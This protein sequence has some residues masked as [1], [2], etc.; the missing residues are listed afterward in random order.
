M[1][2]TLNYEAVPYSGTVVPDTSPQH[3][4]LCAAWH[5]HGSPPGHPFHLV[6]L[7]C[8][9]GTNL[10]ALGFYNPESTF[11]G[12][13]S[14]ATALHIARETARCLKLN[15]VQFVL[16]DVYDVEPPQSQFDYV[17]AHGLYSWV[18]EDVR[19]AILNFCSQ[20]LT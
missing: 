19:D 7:G 13:D 5:Q 18:S 11:T 14:S 16:Q 12:I 3:L 2:S 6:E 4:A 1:P 17:I 10:L 20:S 15:N 9:D 8:G